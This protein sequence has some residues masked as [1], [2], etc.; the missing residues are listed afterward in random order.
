[1]TTSSG[2]SAFTLSGFF[3]GPVGS[4]MSPAA[5]GAAAAVGLAAAPA[6][7]VGAV[8]AAAAGAV[9]GAAPPDGGVVG[10]AAGAAVGDAPPPPEQA[11]SSEARVGAERQTNTARRRTRRRLRP[12]L[13]TCCTAVGVE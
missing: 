10:L 9:V 12:W 13:A 6:A 7:A 4:V 3:A 1:M 8:V 5:C 11:A 2:A